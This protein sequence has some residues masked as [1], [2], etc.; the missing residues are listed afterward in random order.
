MKTLLNRGADVDMADWEG[1][2]GLFYAVTR[3]HKA[4][5][6]ILL[7]HGANIERYYP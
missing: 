1:M 3:D 4:I 7:D 5:V 6:D 2:T